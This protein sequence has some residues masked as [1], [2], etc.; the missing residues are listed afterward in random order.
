MMAISIMPLKRRNFIMGGLALPALA[1][2]ERPP[3]RPNIVCIVADGL[4][5][6]ML[7]CGGNREI[8]TPNIDQLAQAGTRFRNH[9]V[10]TPASSP[11]LATL[12]TG[13]VPR[14]HGIQDFLTGEPLENPPQGQAAAPPTFRNE[15]MLSDLLAGNGYECGFVGEWNLGDD[16]NA[17]HGFGFWYTIDGAIVYQDPH[18]NFS[19]QA[20]AEK[21][22]L[23]DLL[24]AKAGVFL[25]RQTPA[26]PFF[27][28]IGYPNPHPP[29]EGHPARD[30]EMYAKAGFETN[31]WEPAA[32]NALRGKDFLR[33]VVG[34]SR[35]AAAAVTA[36]DDQI[37]R[38]LAKLQQRGLR[39]ST[40][41]IFTGNRGWLLGR[42]GLWS[43]GLASN[44]INMYDEVVQAPMIW[45]WLGHIP[46]ETVRPELVSAYDFVPT[47]CELVD[48]APPAGRNLCG[49][50]YLLPVTGKPLPK[51]SPWR[52]VVFG[53]YRNTE[54]ARD[55]RFK[56]VVRNNGNGPNE[57]FDLANDPRE[58]VNQY[59]NLQY[60]ADVAELARALE[61]WRKSTAS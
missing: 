57:F 49:R 33:D 21:G 53:Q 10:C 46:A 48:I 26:K 1:R 13:R 23:T 50:S 55:E 32:A 29:Y 16:R 2:K 58:K 4:G 17:Q 11:S 45:H 19:G 39:E 59:E 41:V 7:G 61:G 20:V 30:Y 52:S 31:G 18:M 9:L 14:Q 12:L 51:K 27:L 34:N 54:M 8:K 35:K 22:Y 38:I 24:T 36:L 3:A 28:T 40:V 6:W 56:L 15:V 47:V 60:K 37:P 25:D 42:H 5:S 44:P 43:A